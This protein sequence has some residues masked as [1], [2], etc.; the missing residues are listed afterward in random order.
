MYQLASSPLVEKLLLR[1]L[2]STKCQ[3]ATYVKAPA[4]KLS[5]K[6]K[7]PGIRIFFSGD[8]FFNHS[9]SHHTE[10]DPIAPEA[11]GEISMRSSRHGANIGKSVFRGS[12]STRPLK[13]VLKSSAGNY[14]LQ[15]D[16]SARALT[17]NASPLRRGSEKSSS[18]PPMRM[19]LSGV[20]L[21]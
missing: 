11:Q 15:A 19:R 8:P 12:K 9:G 7:K 5:G 4:E 2:L 3:S 17:A 16:S 1:E 13:Y 18:F 10:G 20:V 21:R 14:F 6:T